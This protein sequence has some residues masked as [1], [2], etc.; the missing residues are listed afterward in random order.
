MATGT[1]CIGV[2]SMVARPLGHELHD[3]HA[4]VLCRRAFQRWLVSAAREKGGA[5]GW[6]VLERRWRKVE[7]GGGWRKIWEMF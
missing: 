2:A 6:E 3:A 5:Q 1:R 7:V 4:E